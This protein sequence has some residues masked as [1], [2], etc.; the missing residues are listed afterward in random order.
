MSAALV[1]E[2]DLVDWLRAAGAAEGDVLL[3]H[4]SLSAFGN[5]VG[6]EQAVIA[7]LRRAVGS[8][9][10]IAMPAQSWQLC[11]PDYLADP[12]LDSEQR[13]L[14]RRTLPPFDARLTPTRTMGSVA[15][16]F[17]TLPGVR[18]SPHPHR[19]FSAWGAAADAITGSQPFDDPFGEASP[20]AVLYAL[21]AK[22]VLLGVGY[23]SCTALHLAE[24]RSGRGLGRTVPN[25]APVR[26][27]GERT[28]VEWDEPVVEDADFP[29][30]G[31]AFERS[32]GLSSGR[33][34]AA[35]CRVVPLADLVDFAAAAMH[36]DSEI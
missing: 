16:L 32:A 28:W 19:S 7:A 20:L 27:A 8:A 31:A 36:V 5:V 15:E 29:A 11:D 34:G 12:A 35:V 23:D 17:R 33:V 9:G 22:V 2:D 30:L 24:V 25:G 14:V 4:C 21:R 3:V 18:R 10:T 13:D 26:V 1:T 6:G